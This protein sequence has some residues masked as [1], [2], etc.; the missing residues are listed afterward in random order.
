MTE[1]I[2]PTAIADKLE[3]INQYSTR[4]RVEYGFIEEQL[5]K[6]YNDIDAGLFG[7]N[8]KTGEFYT[9]IKSV[10]DNSPKPDLDT[11]QAE[12]DALMTQHYGE[13]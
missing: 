11:L 9:F 1:P 4:R 12:L 6:L 13:E 5:G 7:E 10:K 8:A 2:I 3:E